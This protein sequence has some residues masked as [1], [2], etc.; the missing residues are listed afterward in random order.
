MKIANISDKRKYI[1]LGIMAVFGIIGII[2]LS[3]L[4]ALVPAL[5]IEPENGVITGHAKVI[6]N[7]SASGGSAVQFGL[8]SLVPSLG[9]EIAVGASLGGNQYQS[10][11]RVDPAN[12]NHMA[13]TIKTGYLEN[14]S[15][16]MTT[17]DGGATWTS[18]ALN[19]SGDDDVVYDKN[20]VLHW[21][22]IDI[23]NRTLGYRRS[24]DGGLTWSITK[25]IGPNID[26]PHIIVDRS[27]SSF[28]G[29]IYIVGTFNMQITRSRDGGLTW[30]TALPTVLPAINGGEVFPP[31]ILQDGTL[32]IPVKGNW[33]NK[34]LNG[35]YNGSA[36]DIY[37]LRSTDGGVTFTGIHVNQ[38]T[39]PAMSGYGGF[40][41]ISMAVG[42]NG[43]GGQRLFMTYS[44]DASNN[45]PFQLEMETSDDDGTTWTSPRQIA[46][47]VPTGWGAGSCSIIVNKNGVIGVQFFSIGFINPNLLFDLDFIYSKDNGLTFSAPMKIPTVSSAEPNNPSQP[48]WIGQDQV[49]G[50]SDSSGAFHLVWTDAR[51]STSNYTIY[52]RVVTVP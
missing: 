27:Q 18:T 17:R 40:N 36:S 5:G 42:P 14:A 47:T 31:A 3:S 25:T 7:T 51:S 43:S 35:V 10:D 19:A 38:V 46:T 20:G 28:N 21:S 22:F 4:H 16:I 24:T 6:A 13:V 12:S 23:S 39:L 37:I 34:T 8:G 41:G 11:L 44:N 33:V 9:P 26:H 50:D 1:P 52:S 2:L 48:R 15:A 30:T 49:E 32:V 45:V 29:S